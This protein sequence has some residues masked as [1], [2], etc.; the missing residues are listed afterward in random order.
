MEKKI[1]YADKKTLNTSLVTRTVLNTK[2]NEI[3]NKIPDT[4]SLV[5][6]T[7]LNT[8]ISEIKKKIPNHDYYYSWIQEI[9]SRKFYSKIKTR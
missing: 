3:E 5:T 2:I 8:K 1:G 7:V 4:S 6:T 9:N